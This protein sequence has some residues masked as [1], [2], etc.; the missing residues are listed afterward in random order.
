MKR[1]KLV[2]IFIM[3]SALKL[4]AQAG[5]TYSDF[6]GV[7]TVTYA[8]YLT[9]IQTVNNPSKTALNTSNN[10][11]KVVSSNSLYENIYNINTLTT[12][13]FSTETGF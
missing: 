13:D 6:D 10:V 9:S 7:N 12:I 3:F 11:G 2:F 1:S 5:V 8:G 4:C